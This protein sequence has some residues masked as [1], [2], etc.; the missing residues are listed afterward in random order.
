MNPLYWLDPWE[1]SPTVVIAIGVAA[2]L[3][4]RGQHKARVT[5]TGKASPT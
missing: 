4:V 5:R 1:P 3:F 2:L